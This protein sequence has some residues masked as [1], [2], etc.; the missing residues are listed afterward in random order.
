V[1]ESARVIEIARVLAPGGGVFIEAGAN[2]GIRQSNSLALE[3]EL[4]WTG[5]LIEPSPKAFSE[6]Q[7]NRPACYLVRAALVSPTRSGQAIEGA[8]R[9]GLLTG[10][11]NA[12]LLPLAMDLPISKFQSFVVR[13]R[14]ALGIKPKTTLISVPTTTL[15]L[16]L[17]DALISNVDLLSLDVEGHE[18]E[19]LMGL[20]FDQVKPKAILLEIRKDDAWDIVR[21]LARFGYVL[22]ENMSNFDEVMSPTWTKDHEDFLFVTLDELLLNSDLQSVLQRK[23]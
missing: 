15:S 23:P 7:T 2:D 14:N 5:L 9:D 17:T 20:D 4:G 6:L 22:V 10:T 21:Y 8:F 11:V 18:L 16:A 12:E 1:I 13:F 19:A 3:R